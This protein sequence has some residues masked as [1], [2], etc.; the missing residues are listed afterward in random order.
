MV[1]I[2]VE[3]C[4][5]CLDYFCGCMYF[6]EALF[7]FNFERGNVVSDKGNLNNLQEQI[8]NKNRELSSYNAKGNE[9]YLMIN[10]E[11][12]GTDEFLSDFEMQKRR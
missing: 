11:F 8:K 3:Y 7:L 1:A 2:V 10:G 4:Y 9:G 12:I 5:I 6:L